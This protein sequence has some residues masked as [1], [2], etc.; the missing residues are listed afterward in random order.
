MTQT[1]LKRA[2]AL[3]PGRPHDFQHYERNELFMEEFGVKGELALDGIT[4]GD[5]GLEDV[6][7]DVD[8][9]YTSPG[10]N[11]L[12]NL[13]TDPLADPLELARRDAF[14]ERLRQDHRLLGKAQRILTDCGYEVA[15][16]YM[17]PLLTETSVAPGMLRLMSAGGLLLLGT[18]VFSLITRSME[19]AMMLVLPVIMI[20]AVLG[21]VVERKEDQSKVRRIKGLQ[22]KG[23]I[24]FHM[25][26]MMNLMN[27]FRAG[28]RLAQ[29]PEL[30]EL[31]PGIREHLPAVRPLIDSFR[32]FSWLAR[33]DLLD[34]IAQ[35]FLVKHVLYYRTQSRLRQD[36]DRLRRFVWAV[37]YVDALVS[38]A[39][40]RDHLDQYGEC[41]TRPV[42]AGQSA[43]LK[44]V[45]GVHPLVEDCVPNSIELTSQ[46]MILTGSNMSGKS[47]FMRVL[48]LNA[49]LAQ[50][51]HMALAS[52][53][54]ASPFRIMSSID[55]GDDVITGKSYFMAEAEAVL[56]IIGS[57]D[58]EFPGLY[59][60]D[61]M[62][63]GTNPTERISASVRIIDYLQARNCLL[64]LATHDRDIIRY[65]TGNFRKCYFTETVESQGLTFDHKLRVGTSG[66]SN[67][68]RILDLLGYPLEITEGAR[69]MVREEMT[70][71]DYQMDP[72]P[73]KAAACPQPQVTG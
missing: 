56:R 44:L 20:N 39:A 14:I 54:E 65:A 60:L 21:G 36:N 1:F 10:A 61:E 53:Y 13:M 4:V 52:S 30:A 50:T 2:Q 59:I 15:S 72:H 31:S 26:S 41:W 6:Y 40:Y 16:D 63:R 38:V 70:L 27:V 69:A 8:R 58:S 64:I 9:T 24:A 18:I 33:V 46:G 35:L 34:Y 57:A 28:V 68:I 47:T 17:L 12:W 51:L 11:V 23:G 32:I 71:L 62:F 19:N 67:A 29:E 45:D 66:T 37:G 3:W 49:I 22:F 42:L 43:R 48:G 55:P 73:G 5:L 25:A 7:A